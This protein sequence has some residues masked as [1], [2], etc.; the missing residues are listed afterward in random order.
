MIHFFSSW[1]SQISRMSRPIDTIKNSLFSTSYR[2]TF[3]A[4][5]LRNI[6][7][8]DLNNIQSYHMKYLVNKQ[9]VFCSLFTSKNHTKKNYKYT[10]KEYGNE[11]TWKSVRIIYTVLSNHCSITYDPYMIQKIFYTKEKKTENN[12]RDVTRIKFVLV[13]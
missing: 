5:L 3:S 9:F 4:I 10:D 2:S 6:F 1:M 11:R 12:Y 13:Y 8:F 7:S